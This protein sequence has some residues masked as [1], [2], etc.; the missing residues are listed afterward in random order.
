MTIADLLAVTGV[1]GTTLTTPIY[2]ENGSAVEWA[3]VAP[4]GT[5]FPA[6]ALIIG[7][8]S[9]PELAQDGA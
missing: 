9:T 5:A 1:T 6:G 7:T 8:S 4:A 2:F 3:H